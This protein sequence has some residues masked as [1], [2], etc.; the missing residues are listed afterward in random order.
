MSR[1][2]ENRQTIQKTSLA[3]IFNKAVTHTRSYTM[4]RQGLNEEIM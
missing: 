2:Q 4:Q 3:I 1:D